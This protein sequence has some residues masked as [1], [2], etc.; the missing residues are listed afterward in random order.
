MASH[1]VALKEEA[2]V[3]TWGKLVAP[4]K[5]PPNLVPG[6]TFETPWRASD[7]HSYPLIPSR[8]TAAAPLISS[9]TF[10]CKLSFPI[11]SF[12]LCGIGKETWQNGNALVVASFGSQANGSRT[13][14]LEEEALKRMSP[15][16]KK[17][18]AEAILWKRMM[19]ACVVCKAK[20][21]GKRCIY[22]LV[23]EVCSKNRKWWWERNGLMIGCPR[24]LLTV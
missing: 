10:S 4:G 19:S 18:V 6:P 17:A 12:T 14:K 21:W 9:L 8:G 5:S 2:V 3:M 15:R 1:K 23:G 13:A 11:R 20:G 16:R 22:R 7:H 24:G